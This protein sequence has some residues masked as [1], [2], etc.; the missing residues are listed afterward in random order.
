M[1]DHCWSED[2][3]LVAFYLSRYGTRFLGMGEA[4]IAKAL[5]RRP[6]PN[7]CRAVDMPEG[8]L[9]MRISNFDYLD[10]RPG[11]ENYAAQSFRTYEKYKNATVVELRPIVIRVLEA[12]IRDA[13]ERRFK[14][15]CDKFSGQKFTG[16]GV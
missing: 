15:F 1:A 5:S 4:A 6:P 8:S 11:L 12:P 9:R 2:D 16:G 7:G 3:D 10:G 13:V 14:E